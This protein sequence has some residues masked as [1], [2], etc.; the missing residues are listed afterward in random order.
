MPKVAAMIDTLPKQTARGF[1]VISEA[2]SSLSLV[3]PA[4]AFFLIFFLAF[5][6]L[7]LFLFFIIVG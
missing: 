7:F 1:V 2:C 6:F 4:T 3:N 5:L